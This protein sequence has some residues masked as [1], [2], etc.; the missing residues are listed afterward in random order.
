[1][2]RCNAR[3]GNGSADVMR[4]T[5]LLGRVTFGGPGSALA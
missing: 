5:D 1:M 3:K 2:T 4:M